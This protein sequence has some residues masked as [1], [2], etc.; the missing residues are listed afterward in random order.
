MKAQEPA[1]LR[2]LWT[3][4]I[5][6]GV[7][8]ITH[9]LA[10]WAWAA[11]FRGLGY[12]PGG[13]LPSY[14][15]GVS[16][17]GQVVVG[18]AESPYGTQAFMW[19]A[20][21]GMVPLGDTSGGYVES[22]A[23]AVSRDGSV[24]VG[25][26]RGGEAFRWTAGTGIVGLGDLPGGPS[27]STANG[28]SGDGSIVIGS[29]GTDAGREAFRWTQTTGLVGLGDLPGGYF[30]SEASAISTDGRVIV[31]RALS[32][33]SKEPFMWTADGGMV[34]L[35]DLNGGGVEGEAYGVSTDGTVIVGYG[36]SAMGTEAFRWTAESGMV[37]L[38]ILPGGRY[39]A[40][41]AVSADGSVIVGYSE[42]FFQSQSEAFIW[43]AAHG[44]RHLADVL[45]NDF[46]LGAELA[47]WTLYDARGISA[48]GMVIA[49]IG[50]GPNGDEAWIA[51]LRPAPLAVAI[52]IQPGSTTNRIN[53]KKG[54]PVPVAILSSAQFDAPA[55]VD[56]TSL[57]FGRT[58]DEASLT[59]C[60][61][62]AKDVNSDGLSDLVC[63]FSTAAS[64]FQAGDTEGVLK[65]RTVSDV[66]II[67]SDSVTIITGK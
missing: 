11:S 28:V 61:R 4:L 1:S 65:G 66:S 46:G 21:G 16:A 59:S 49:G 30:D 9:A 34:G 62:R 44:M 32:A 54:G 17:D 42:T 26:Q 29:G 63:S 67:G 47:G 36:S 2:F 58:G 60:N 41:K 50:G 24:I 56:R 13:G 20:A 57:T 39:S 55:Q 38:G 27:S 5:L 51:D 52:D 64:G 6:A 40:A 15:N 48:D 25:Y 45:S 22:V 31:G 3:A 14:A 23:E 35:G 8:L 43:D 7:L 12:L 33:A 53:L 18:R 37:G 19:T 10:D